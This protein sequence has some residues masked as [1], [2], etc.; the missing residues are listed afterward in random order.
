MARYGRGLSD[1]LDFARIVSPS[2]ARQDGE[3]PVRSCHALGFPLFVRK[4]LAPHRLIYHSAF[5]MMPPNWWAIVP[6]QL[7]EQCLC[8]RGFI[9]SVDEASRIRNNA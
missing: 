4:A 8:L 6:Q 9:I 7:D 1:G 2:A 5:S 3:R